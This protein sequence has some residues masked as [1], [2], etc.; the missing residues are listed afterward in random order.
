MIESTT[1]N[2]LAADVDAVVNTVNTVGVMGKGIALQFKRAYPDMFKAYKKACDRGDVQLGKMWVWHNSSF[3]GPRHIVNFPTKGHWRSGSKLADIEAGLVDLV[4]VIDALDISSIA[5]PPLGCGNGGLD[6]SVVRP[7]IDEHLGTLR[8]V[9]IQLFEP[10]GSPASRDMI[11][12]T[13]RPNMSPGKAALV[14]T[15]SRYTEVALETSVVEV[16]KLM[17]FLQEAGQPLRLNYAKDRYGP[18]ADNLSKVLS[19]VERHFLTGFGD[20]SKRVADSEP[21]EVLPGALDQALKTLAEDSE[22]QK[23]IDRVLDLV[24]GFESAY[25]LELMATVHWVATRIEAGSHDAE[26]ITRHVH[27]W[28]A[29]KAGLFTQ[30]HVESVLNRL[31]EA[32]FLQSA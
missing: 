8:S 3:E 27:E 12:R 17:Y 32:R 30:P 5:L 7:I 18:Y 10:K 14:S 31:T 6:W 1:G 19:A 15:I 4:A 23:R 20:G 21:I 26:T 16:Q 13:P 24:S 22:T 11:V 2:L 25:F 28:N 9:E 29:R